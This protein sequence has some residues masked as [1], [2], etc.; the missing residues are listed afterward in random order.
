MGRVWDEP[1]IGNVPR[2]WTM[3]YER[4]EVMGAELLRQGWAKALDFILQSVQTLEGEG[5]IL[6]RKVCSAVHAESVG[7]DLVGGS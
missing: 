1:R 4:K 7:I 5:S 2:G 3:D 6:G